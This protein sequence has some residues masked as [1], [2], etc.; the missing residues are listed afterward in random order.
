MKPTRKGCLFTKLESCKERSDE[1]FSSRV[2]EVDI[3]AL[4]HDSYNL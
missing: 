1:L 2:D 3:S 4:L